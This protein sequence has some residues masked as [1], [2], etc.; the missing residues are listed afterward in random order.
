MSNYQKK[1]ALPHEIRQESL[2]CPAERCA[3]AGVTQVTS[4]QD[5][6]TLATA[7]PSRNAAGSAARISA[8]VR[9]NAAG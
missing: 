3:A 5:A 4:A 6:V 8:L 2:L 9:A 7:F 1:D